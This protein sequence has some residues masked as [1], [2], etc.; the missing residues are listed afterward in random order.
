MFMRLCRTRMFPTTGVA[1]GSFTS[2]PSVFRLE[3]LGCF[4][5]RRETPEVWTSG[6]I[7]TSTKPT[8]MFKPALSWS[9]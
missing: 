4:A 7:V 5:R 3:G 9:M 2:L 8:R 1:G 6:G